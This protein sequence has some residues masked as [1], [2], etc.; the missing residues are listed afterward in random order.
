M[1]SQFTFQS[2]ILNEQAAITICITT[3][4]IADKKC[5]RFENSL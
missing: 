1:T 4:K 2:V 5:T 3:S